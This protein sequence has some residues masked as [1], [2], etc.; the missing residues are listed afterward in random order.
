MKWDKMRWELQDEIMQSKTATSEIKN[1][2]DV[3]KLQW[4]F[5]LCHI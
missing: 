3:T 4:N 5:V 1:E 2:N